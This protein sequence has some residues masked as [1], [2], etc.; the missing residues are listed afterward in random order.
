MGMG[1]SSLELP[2]Q[3]SVEQRSIRILIQAKICEK[4]SRM[5]H[6]NRAWEPHINLDSFT[7]NAAR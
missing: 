1:P 4:Y 2:N 7:L 6:V 3:L 5:L